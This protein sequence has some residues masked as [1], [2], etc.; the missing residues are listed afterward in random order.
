MRLDAALIGAG[1]TF[2]LIHQR[3][4]DVLGLF[5]GQ[6]DRHTGPNHCW[7]PTLPIVN[8]PALG[9][10]AN[11]EPGWRRRLVALLHFRSRVL[12]IGPSPQ[13]FNERPPAERIVRR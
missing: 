8:H 1:P 9:P 13:S 2:A 12:I 6:I 11:Q 4:L 3:P 5:F 7:P 10:L